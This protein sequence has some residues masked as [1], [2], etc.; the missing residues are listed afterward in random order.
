MQP[1]SIVAAVPE[2]Q[3]LVLPVVLLALWAVIAIMLSVPQTARAQL[4]VVNIPASTLTSDT[5]WLASNL[6]VVQGDVYVAENVALTIQPGTVVKFAPSTRL[7]INGVL[8]ARGTS[9][10]RI[11]FTSF[12]DDSA[13][14]DTDGDGAATPPAKADWG[15]IQFND[16][17]NDTQSALDHADVRYSGH[18][19]VGCCDSTTW[20]AITLIDASPTLNDISFQLNSINGVGIPGGT[21]SGSATSSTEVWR[22]TGV[23]YTVVGDLVIANGFRLVIEPGLIVK[24]TR[25]NRLIVEGALDARGTATAPITFTSFQDDTIGGDTDADGTN[26][27]PA[28]ADWGWIEFR[29]TSDD[30]QSFLE[31]A[32]LRYS[33]LDNLGCCDQTRWGAVTLVDAAPTLSHLTFE[34]NHINGVAI[35]GG[36]KNASAGISEET[37]DNTDVVYVVIGDV[38]IADG[39]K[40][41]ITPGMIVKFAN[42]TRLINEGILDAR[43]TPSAPINLTSLNDDTIAG[44]TDSDGTNTPPAKN[45]WGWIEFRDS[46]NDTLSFLHYTRLRYGGEENLGC[47]DVTRWGTVTLFNA[48]PNLANLTFEENYVNG[49]GIPEVT[50]SASTTASS[51]TWNTQGITYVVLGHVVIA[52]G[53]Q[54]NIAPGTVVKFDDDGRIEVRGALNAQGTSVQ[55]IVFTSFQ[56]DASG[57]DTDADGSNTPPKPGDWRG[58]QFTDTSDDAQNVLDYTKVLYGTTISATGAASRILHSEI[59]FNQRGFEL[60]GNADSLIEQNRIANNV[61]QGIFVSNARPIIRQNSISDNGTFGV[62]NETASICVDATNNWWGHPSGP[63]DSGDR[64]DSC[65]LNASTGQ[66][67]KVSDNVRYQPWHTTPTGGVLALDRKLYLPISI[68]RGQ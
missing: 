67:Q 62:F 49:I 7:I 66:G 37:W 5:T 56:D 18:D 12:Q 48:S 42:R 29:E 25:S 68:R 63:T 14:G 13:G 33:G 11:V 59:A 1:S 39:F 22:N 52:P 57:G 10:N 36:T 17:S 3:N 32:R 51:E 21:K 15:W 23:V 6:Y 58:I 61:E 43:G 27:P 45:D 8:N 54:L 50:K 35:P 46:S 38:V 30:S 55:S 2:R 40:L 44:D 34:Q 47:C 9:D 16:T 41:T 24:V 60:R 4:P 26:T 28:K 31:H 20:G 64:T 53:F 65:G 19:N